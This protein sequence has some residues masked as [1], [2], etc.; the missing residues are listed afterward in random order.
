MMSGAMACEASMA[1]GMD[2]TTPI[3]VS[4]KNNHIRLRWS[5]HYAAAAVAG[6]HIPDAAS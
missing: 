6:I 1:V 5:H 4:A 3:V 2:I